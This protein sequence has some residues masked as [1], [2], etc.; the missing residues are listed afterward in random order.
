MFKYSAWGIFS[1]PGLY[2]ILSKVINGRPVISESSFASVDF[3]PPVLPKMATFFI[4]LPITF[5]KVQEADTKNPPLGRVLILAE[6]GM[7]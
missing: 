1:P 4:S 7:V 6:S 2:I 5:V 3:P